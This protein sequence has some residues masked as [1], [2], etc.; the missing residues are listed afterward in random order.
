MT[1]LGDNNYSNLI[2]KKIQTYKISEKVS[3][4]VV[5]IHLALVQGLYREMWPSLSTVEQ[6]IIKR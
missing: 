6:S 3:E 5:Q 2:K 1:I 4:N